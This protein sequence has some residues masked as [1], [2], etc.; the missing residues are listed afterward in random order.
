MDGAFR[1]ARLTDRLALW[2]LPHPDPLAPT[3]LYLHGTFRNL[4]PNYPKIEALRDAGFASSRWTTV[5]GAR[6]RRGAAE[7]TDRRGCRRGLGRA[8]SDASP[9]RAGG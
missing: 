1:Q 5:A 9:T 7:K 2:W 3:L 8:A 6:A 4:Y